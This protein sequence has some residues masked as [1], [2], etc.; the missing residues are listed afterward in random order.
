MTPNGNY[1][2]TA[3]LLENEPP[4]VI[5]AKRLSMR[6]RLPYVDLHPTDGQSPIDYALLAEIPVDMMLKNHFVPLKRVGGKLYVAMAD[7]TNLEQ[8][9]E[10]ETSLKARI[11]AHVATAGAIE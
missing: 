8:L 7:P 1:N 5:E 2:S 6:Y 4:E 11:V 10:L 3:T 9:D